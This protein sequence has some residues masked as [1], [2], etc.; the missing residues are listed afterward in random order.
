M[1]ISSSCYL[2]TSYHQKSFNSKTLIIIDVS[3]FV[4]LFFLSSLSFF[5]FLSSNLLFLCSIRPFLPSVIAHA[6]L[7]FLCSLLGFK[8]CLSGHLGILSVSVPTFALVS[9]RSPGWIEEKKLNSAHE[10]H[11]SHLATRLCFRDE[12]APYFIKLNLFRRKLFKKR[13]QWFLIGFWCW[14]ELR[15]SESSFIAFSKFQSFHK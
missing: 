13:K 11:I 9:S 14:K 2:K 5:L 3:P 7:L 6:L 12:K 10:F 15:P 8:C 4:S 1:S